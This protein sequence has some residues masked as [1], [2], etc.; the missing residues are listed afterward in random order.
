MHNLQKIF[1]TQKVGGSSKIYY[2]DF[3]ADIYIREKKPRSTSMPMTFIYLLYIFFL[4][5]ASPNLHD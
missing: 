1:A 2:N 3:L 4:H 5:L